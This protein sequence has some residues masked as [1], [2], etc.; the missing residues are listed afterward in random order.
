M[1]RKAVTHSVS[2]DFELNVCFCSRFLNSSRRCR[3]TSIFCM[4]FS[5]PRVR[6][7][8]WSLWQHGRISFWLLFPSLNPFE[9]LNLFKNRFK[10]DMKN[11]SLLPLF[12]SSLSSFEGN[13]L[14]APGKITHGHINVFILF[15]APISPKRHK[16]KECPANAIPVLVK[17]RIY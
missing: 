13:S 5:D 3:S 2:S 9:L 17:L 10:N 15:W 1:R 6:E 7:G 8:G 4:C 11:P 14:H 12:H 16:A